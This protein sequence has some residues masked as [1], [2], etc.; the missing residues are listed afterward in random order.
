MCTY[1]SVEVSKLCHFFAALAV[2]ASVCFPAEVSANEEATNKIAEVVSLV[3][4]AGVAGEP[5][6]HELAAETVLFVDKLVMLDRGA[7]LVVRY[8]TT[9]AVYEL[10]GAGLVVMQRDGPLVVEGEKAI[11]LE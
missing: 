2:V 3:G 9:Q 5:R 10:R 1:F 8:T 7:V 6:R 11:R 4:G